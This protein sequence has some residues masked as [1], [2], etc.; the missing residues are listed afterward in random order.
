M[1]SQPDLFTPAALAEHESNASDAER[2]EFRAALISA[3]TWRTRAQLCAT[4]NCSD[5]K[6]RAIAES[7]GS[8]VVRCQHGFKL[9]EQ[10]TPEEEP[11]VREAIATFRSQAVKM[12]EY[13]KSLARRLLLR[14]S[15]S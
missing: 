9:L 4:L 13:S 7:L 2:S 5:R 12:E 10:I 1:P 3:G 8:E 15:H 11:I 14:T 6:V